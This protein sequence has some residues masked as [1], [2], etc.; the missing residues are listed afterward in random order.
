M[1]V[2]THANAMRQRRRTRQVN[3]QRKNRTM[4]L[5]SKMEGETGSLMLHDL[6][7]WPGVPHGAEECWPGVLVQQPAVP[8]VPTLAG[9]FRA[10]RLKARRVAFSMPWLRRPLEWP[11]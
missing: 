5:R 1:I 6:S 4:E 9:G 10:T 11:N 3:N 8:S 2:T 7:L